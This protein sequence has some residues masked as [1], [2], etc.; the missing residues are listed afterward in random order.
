MIPELLCLLDLIESHQKI[1]ISY[2][3]V[4][5]SITAF[6]GNVIIIVAL[7]N[8]SSLHQ[9][10]KLLLGCLASTDLCVGLI[11]QPLFAIY[12]MST[13][14]PKRCYYT[15]V[16]SRTIGLIFSGV[17]LMT[18]TAISSDRLLALEL[19]LRYRQVVTVRK[20]CA[21]VFTFWI[22]NTAIAITYFYNPRVTLGIAGVEVLSCIVIS[23]FCYTRI[24]IKLRHHQAQVQDNVLQGQPNGGAN[25]LNI[26]RYKK[27]VS[28]ALWVQM[29]L[30][31]CYLPNGI[32]MAVQAISG[33][34]TPSIKFT[35]AVTS[36]LVL[37]NSS[38]NPFLYCWKMKE[39][40][41]SVKDT[42]RQFCCG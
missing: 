32:V 11:T 13:E 16:L 42:F 34:Q 18:L 31:A 2:L 24:Y 9:P 1:T 7:Q 3:N 19:G 17:S 12:L 21:S 35:W 5:F 6:W 40:R 29:T 28:S 26:A 39:V 27:T 30:L 25:P 14:Q 20:A 36:F 4:P 22:S 8:V 10:S 15:G 38:L 23:T 37:F 41:Q 33:L